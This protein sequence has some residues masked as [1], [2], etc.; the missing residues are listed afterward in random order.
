[1]FNH[2][3]IKINCMKCIRTREISYS[4]YSINIE[5]KDKNE[6]KR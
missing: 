4:R 2:Y 3:K 5:K 6:R 1:M